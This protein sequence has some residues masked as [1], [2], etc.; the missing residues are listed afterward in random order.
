MSF[1]YIF[2]F[3]DLL[4]KTPKL[5]EYEMI[6]RYIL[7]KFNVNIMYPYRHNKPVFINISVV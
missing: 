4:Y 3:I 7:Y 5:N 6:L 1:S 2:F